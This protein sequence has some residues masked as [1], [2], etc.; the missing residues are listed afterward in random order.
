MQLYLTLLIPGLTLMGRLKLGTLAATGRHQVCLR[1]GPLVARL[2][3]TVPGPYGPMKAATAPITC[4]AL[5]F[6][7]LAWYWR[8]G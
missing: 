5:R 1:T 3:P 6:P 8:S 2:E 7:S 4:T